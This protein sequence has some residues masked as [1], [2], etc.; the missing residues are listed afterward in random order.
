MTLRSSS[1]RSGFLASVVLAGLAIPFA[2]AHA[3]AFCEVRKTSDGFVAL[4]DAPSG[5]GKRIWRLKPGEIV[6][7]DTTRPRKKGWAAV[8]YRSEDQKIQHSGWVSDRLIEKE[9]G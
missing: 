5:S 9:C 7:L 8:I 6:Q 2:P 3:T 1:F 4:R